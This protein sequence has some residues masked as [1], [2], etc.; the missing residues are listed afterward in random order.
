[1]ELRQLGGIRVVFA[2]T[3]LRLRY[4]FLRK[5]TRVN[6]IPMPRTFSI[7]RLRAAGAQVARCAG[8]TENVRLVGEGR[9]KRTPARRW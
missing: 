2:G 4:T 5:L 6:D 9:G 3:W 8:S 7:V 1:M